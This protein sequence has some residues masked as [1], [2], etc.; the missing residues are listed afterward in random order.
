MD[1]R[2]VLLTIDEERTT[3]GSVAL[4]VGWKTV[5]PD[6]ETAIAQ[7]E[8]E[9]ARVAASAPKTAAVRTDDPTVIGMAAS[10]DHPLYREAVEQLFQRIAARPAGTQRFVGTLV[11][12]R[13]LMHHFD[14][15]A[16]RIK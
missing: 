11:I 1:E 3:L 15:P 8:D 16:L 9:I 7:V 5:S 10:A 14:L 4:N 6:L 2:V 13:E 12:L